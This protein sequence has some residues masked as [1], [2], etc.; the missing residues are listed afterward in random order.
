MCRGGTSTGGGVTGGVLG[1][2]TFANREASSFTEDELAAEVGTVGCS[3]PRVGTT[4]SVGSSSS[5]VGGTGDTDRPG[6]RDGGTGGGLRSRLADALK[7][8][9]DELDAAAER[10]GRVAK[11]GVGREAGFGGGTLKLPVASSAPSRGLPLLEVV[12]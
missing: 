1:A 3:V 8:V 12:S 10:V 7:L 11:T 9:A 4:A 6:L 2:E 5:D